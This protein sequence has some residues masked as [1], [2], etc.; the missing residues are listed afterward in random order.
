LMRGDFAWSLES[1]KQKHFP[2]GGQKK[3]VLLK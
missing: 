1:G 2:Y 3:E